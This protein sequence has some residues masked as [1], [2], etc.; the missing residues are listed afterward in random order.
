[1]KHVEL[2]KT[3]GDLFQC[4]NISKLAHTFR[5]NISGGQRSFELFITQ[6]LNIWVTFFA[7]RKC[8]QWC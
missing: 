4:C 6:I 7:R 2:V 3:S 8:C 1:M 5:T